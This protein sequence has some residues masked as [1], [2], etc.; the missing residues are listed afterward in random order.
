MPRKT[1]AAAAAAPATTRELA[2]DAAAELFVER[3][4]IQAPL[5]ELAARLNITKAAL[6]YHFDS[7]EHI[8]LALV[9]PL[10]DRID[11]LVADSARFGSTPAGR[12]DFL[13]VYAETLTSDPRAVALLGRDLNVAQ[14]PSVAPRIERHVSAVTRVLAGPRPSQEALMRA[15]VAMTI[16]QRGLVVPADN[17]VILANVSTRNYRR[18]LVELAKDIL[19]RPRAD[20]GRPE[21]DALPES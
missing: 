1:G 17:D 7:K 18:Y 19:V 15:H 11:A 14:Q 3:G 12:R 6:Y 16:V 4:Y 9:G 21:P 13:E 8:L 20:A 5:S 10:L 2:L